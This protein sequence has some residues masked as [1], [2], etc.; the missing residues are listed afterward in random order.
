MSAKKWYMKWCPEKWLA[1]PG[2][3]SLSYAARGLWADMLNLMHGAEPYG[4]L[5]FNGMPMTAQKLAKLTNGRER[6]VERLLKE[7]E[8][9][10]VFSRNSDGFIFNRHMI[11]DKKLEE[12]GRFNA[13]KKHAKQ[14]TEAAESVEEVERQ[15]INP[16]GVPIAKIATNPSTLELE[17]ESELDKKEKKPSL[18]SG[19]RPRSRA[20]SQLP[21]DWEPRQQDLTGESAKA[22]IAAGIDLDR[23]T[24][25]FRDYW[26]AS[27]GTKLDWDAAYRF[28][29]SN[30]PG[31]LRNRAAPAP[32]PLSK[33][34]NVGWNNF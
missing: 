18:R 25:K 23:E 30:A 3:R 21:K 27:G 28:W 29:L 7:L 22:A 5:A 10:G 12:I 8:I 1:D 33:V 2:V 16:T 11:R 31:L 32:L 6:E 14:A 34:S 26:R 4:H 19:S 9:S 15:P 17:L 24:S 20:A 13:G